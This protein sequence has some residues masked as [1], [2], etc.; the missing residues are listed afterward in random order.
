MYNISVPTIRIVSVISY[1][2]VSDF[3]LEPVQ[4]YSVLFVSVTNY[5]FKMYCLY[6]Y[7]MHVE[8]KFNSLQ[9]L[10]QFVTAAECDKL[11]AESREIVKF[12]IDGLQ[13]ARSQPN[14]RTNM[15]QIN[16][17]AEEFL[18]LLLLF[19]AASSTVCNEFLQL[20]GLAE[21]R[22]ALLLDPNE[23]DSEGTTFYWHF[24]FAAEI[25]WQVLRAE[26]GRHL[27][28]VRADKVI[29][30]GIH[31]LFVYFVIHT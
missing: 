1:L 5:M 17:G 27:A 7:K 3:L 28:A 8:I 14:R 24:R 11:L 6:R 26:N 16:S 9:V 4:Y 22:A 18:E 19:C 13:N 31:T 29:L 21:L 10:A 20:D 15:F 25:L 30:S 12:C 2:L 23:K